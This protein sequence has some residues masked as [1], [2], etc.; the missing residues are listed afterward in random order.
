M[1]LLNEINI[2]ENFV[3]KC[4]YRGCE[5]LRRNG[6]VPGVQR[7]LCKEWKGTCTIFNHSGFQDSGYLLDMRTRPLLLHLE[8]LRIQAIE[9]F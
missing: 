4:K 3:T 9:R 7:G 5:D 1:Q 2:F 8:G 6:F